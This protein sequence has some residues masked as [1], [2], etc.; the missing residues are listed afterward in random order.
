MA[1]DYN[2][3]LKETVRRASRH[4]ALEYETSVLVDRDEGNTLVIYLKDED[5]DAEPTDLRYTLSYAGK[6][7]TDHLVK[8]AG[9]FVADIR[10][11]EYYEVTLTAV[12]SAIF[13]I[14]YV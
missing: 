12:P 5:R 9:P 14:L 6:L 1:A 13:A 7:G 3:F 8:V 10:Q 2:E 11:L 4:G